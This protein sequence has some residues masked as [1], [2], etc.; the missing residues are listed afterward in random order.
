MRIWQPPGLLCCLICVRCGICCFSCSHMQR[1]YA[2]HTHAEFHQRIPRS[3]GKHIRQHG[4]TSSALHVCVLGS[5]SAIVCYLFHKR[6][7]LFF[8]F[9][10]NERWLLHP[11]A[12]MRFTPAH[13]NIH[14]EPQP[15]NTCFLSEGSHNQGNGTA[16]FAALPCVVCTTS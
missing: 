1:T 12:S 8:I 16:D 11:P 13:N 6:V 7:S 9:I 2:K 4:L 3:Q 15:E 10:Q 5:H 14:Y